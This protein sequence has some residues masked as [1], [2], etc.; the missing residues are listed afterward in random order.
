MQFLT[1]SVMLKEREKEK[2]KLFQTSNTNYNRRQAPEFL[3]QREN[4]IANS[5]TDGHSE[6]QLSALQNIITGYI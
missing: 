5:I 6:F 1:V 3:Q 2:K 4:S